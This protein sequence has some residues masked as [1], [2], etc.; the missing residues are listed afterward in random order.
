MSET[1]VETPLAETESEIKMHTLQTKV[2]TWPELHRGDCQQDGGKMLFHSDGTGTWSCTTLTYQTHTHDVWHAR[3]AIKG[4]NGA[5]LF[6]VGQFDSPG[7]SDGNPPPKYTWVRQ[8]AFPPDFF[9]AIASAT[10]TCSC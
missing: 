4:S 8:F 9:N 1:M 7:M 2:L 10:Q 6:N 3:F 5:T